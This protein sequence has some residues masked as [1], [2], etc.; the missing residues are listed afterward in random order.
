MNQGPGPGLRPT[1]VVIGGGYGGVNVAKA[2]DETSM[3]CWSSPRTR[4]CT[5][6]GHC[7]PSSIRRSCPRSSCP[8]TGSSPTGVSSA[9]RAVEVSAHRVVLAS[10]E[11][12]AADLHRP[13]NRIGVPVP[14]QEQR[15]RCRRRD[16]QLSGRAR[17]ADPREPCPARRR[18]SRRHRA[19][20]RDHREVAGQARHAPRPLRRCARRP[21]PSRPAR[22]TAQATR[23]SSASSSSWAKDSTSFHR[24]SRASSRRSR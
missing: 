11:A 10:G 7:G 1:V 19:R 23:R 3:S 15:A 18:R 9:N 20:G 2:L 13:R 17:R 14:R 4:S 8:T 6:S 24:R 21:I 16:R 5:T 22:R 12:I